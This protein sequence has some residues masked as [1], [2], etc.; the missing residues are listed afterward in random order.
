[1]SLIG[2]LACAIAFTIGIS[3]FYFFRPVPLSWTICVEQF[4]PFGASWC[5]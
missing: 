3:V 2:C 1:M 4:D 5:G